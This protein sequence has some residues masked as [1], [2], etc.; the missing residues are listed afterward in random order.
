MDVCVFH[1]FGLLTRALGINILCNSVVASFFVCKAERATLG[2]EMSVLEPGQDIEW[3]G[4]LALLEAL[5]KGA[6]LPVVFIYRT[7][8]LAYIWLVL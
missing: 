6:L 3:K 2:E 7:K 8:I 1:F 5:S 4:S